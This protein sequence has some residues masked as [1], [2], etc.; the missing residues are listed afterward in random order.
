MQVPFIPNG[1]Q[2]DKQAAFAAHTFAGTLFV[3]TEGKLVYSL[4]GKSRT[5]PPDQPKTKGSADKGKGEGKHLRKQITPGWVLTETFI[6][7]NRQPL[8]AKP[9]GYRPAQAKAS[10]MIGA[11][12]PQGSR[13]T[14]PLD[15]FE[16]VRLGE[17]FKGVEVELR[18]T[19]SNVEKI[20]TVK[21]HQ[22]PKQIRLRGGGRKQ[23]DAGQDWRTDRADRQRAQ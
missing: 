11:N 1:G 19:G 7:A 8:A 23:I 13:H 21:P 2:W 20:F 10:Y 6:G 9:A 22:D 14:K 12:N 17:V 18:A 3:T 16:R 5:D 15:S 4:P